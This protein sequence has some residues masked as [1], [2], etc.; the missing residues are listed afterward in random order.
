MATVTCPKCGLKVRAEDGECFACGTKLPRPR[1]EP[2]GYGAPTQRTVPQRQ[3][4]YQ[5]YPSRQQGYPTQSHADNTGS[6]QNTAAGGYGS[7]PQGSMPARDSNMAYGGQTYS[8]DSLPPPPPIT[9]SPASPQPAP[10]PNSK[11]NTN[12]GQPA[13]KPKKLKPSTLSIVAFVLSIV[14]FP[15]GLILGIVDLVKNDREHS[16]GFSI[17]AVIIG[18][19]I[20]FGVIGS[21][22]G[23]SSSSTKDSDDHVAKESSVEALP[24]E[25]EKTPEPVREEVAEEPPSA[26]EEE[27]EP[28]TQEKISIGDEFGNKTIKGVVTYADL[29]YRDYDEAWTKVDDGY[30]AVYIKIKVTNIS[31]RSNYV[32]VGDFDCYVD[33]VITDADMFSGGNEEYNANIDPGRSA[34]LGAMYIVPQGTEHIELEYKPI[35]EFSD[36][37]TIVIQDGPV[38]ETK[39]GS[40]DEGVSGGDDVTASAENVIGIGDEF[41]N[42]TITSI[43]TDVDLDY[44]GYNDMFVTVGE[45]QKVVYIKIKVTNKS[46]SSNYVSVGDFSCYVDN[47]I[48]KAEVF[49]SENDDYNANIDPG[50]SAV[51][52]AMYIVPSDVSSIELEYNPIGES[53]DRVIIKIL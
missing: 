16:H 9:P 41:G 51:L 22:V 12:P 29:D 15:V 44:K 48:T 24:A 46:D 3:P 4:D 34:M 36:T 38:S 32:S 2:D 25:D 14:V 39:I 43:V 23:D 53:A 11:P 45:G 40:A 52:G 17:A 21:Q 30:K 6:Y 49:N 13:T 26:A 27:P 20:T 18:T 33:N 7:I 19:L 10:N 1:I 31:D 8:R 37:P 35:G 50:R 42:K 28:P 47:T 5:G